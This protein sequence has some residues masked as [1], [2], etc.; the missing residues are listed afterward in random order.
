MRKEELEKKIKEERFGPDP[1]PMK[2]F[3]D[4]FLLNWKICDTDEQIRHRILEKIE[5]G[6]KWTVIRGLE[7]VETVLKDSSND[8]KILR[9][10]LYEANADLVEEDI[11]H[12]RAWVEEKAKWVSSILE[13]H[14]QGRG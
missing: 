13:A 9:L 11:P 7:A 14:G 10:V 8:E 5:S 3:R 1:N 12:A 4:L 2:S 6:V